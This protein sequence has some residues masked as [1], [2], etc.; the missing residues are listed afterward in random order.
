MVETAIVTTASR[1]K[2]AVEITTG[3]SHL[4]ADEP[5]SA[6]GDNLGPSPHELL[7]A[8]LGA[9]T[10]MTLRLY[11]QRKGIVLDGMSVSLSRRKL[12]A[13]DCPDCVSTDGEIEEITRTI[14]LP[15]ALDDTTRQRLL[16]IANKCPV[17]RTLMGEIKIRSSL[18]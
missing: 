11:A 4:V 6:G 7:L 8:G 1:G 9:C 15:P 18:A 12:K 5:L 2:F 16:E 10:A 13:A 14:T 3:T 17:H